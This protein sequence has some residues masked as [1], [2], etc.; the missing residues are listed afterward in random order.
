VRVDGN[1]ILEATGVNFLNPALTVEEMESG[2][3]YRWRSVTTGNQV[4]L[5]LVLEHPDV[6]R[7]S[8]VT[9]HATLDVAL[10]DPLEEPL[11]KGA[12]GLGRT[13]S[14][15][16]VS[17][18]GGPLAFATTCEVERGTKETP[19]YVRVTQEDCNRAWSSPIYLLDGDNC[20]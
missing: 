6:G 15:F 13:L 7:L 16:R 12:G 9:N 3:A 8:I 5:D 18:E 14:A 17:E 4:G 19:V 2:R 10:S 20:A 1:R 11:L